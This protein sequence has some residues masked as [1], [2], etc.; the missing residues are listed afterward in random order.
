MP[1]DRKQKENDGK[2]C[3]KKCSLL[4]KRYVRASG[5]RIGKEI[6]EEQKEVSASGSREKIN[7][8]QR[9]FV[10]SYWASKGMLENHTRRRRKNNHSQIVKM[11]KKPQKM[12]NQEEEVQEKEKIKVRLTQRKARRRKRFVNPVE[13]RSRSKERCELSEER[14]EQEIKV[15]RKLKAESVGLKSTSDTDV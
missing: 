6:E 4:S 12:E 1:V 2:R 9:A 10:A 13:K 3:W 7:E 11:M 5:Q 8:E 15:R 14:E